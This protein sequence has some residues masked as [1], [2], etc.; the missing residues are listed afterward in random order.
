MTDETKDAFAAYLAILVAAGE[1]TED[2]A[3][4]ICQILKE[5]YSC[6]TAS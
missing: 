6:E 2:Q 1:I 4:R 5:K 3:L